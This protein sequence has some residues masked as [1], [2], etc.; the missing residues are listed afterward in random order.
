MPDNK[1]EII[2]E[3]QGQQAV[4]TIN[5]VG[6]A[7]KGLDK[8][9]VNA[10]PA[11]I[12]FGR[13]I[14]D[15]P[16]GLIGIANNID[17]LISS[18]QALKTQSGS[19][20]AAFKALAGSLI[21][22]AGIGIAISAVTSAL[23]AFGPKLFGASKEAKE[24]DKALSGVAKS[25][26]DDLVKLQTYASFATD[27]TKSYD[28]RKKAV[29]A[30]KHEYP[31]YLKNIDD[32]AILM[33]KA[34]EAINKSIDAILKR[35][36][37]KL[38]QDDIAK[39]VEESAKKIIE[40]QKNVFDAQQKYIN[41]QKHDTKVIGDV[42]NQ[43]AEALLKTGRAATDAGLGFSKLAQ[44]ANRSF[45]NRPEEQIKRIK[46]Q[47]QALVAPLLTISDEFADFGKVFDGKA[48][49][50]K[51]IREE[52]EKLAKLPQVGNALNQISGVFENIGTAIEKVDQEELKKKTK[53]IEDFVRQVRAMNDI[54]KVPAGPVKLP[55]IDTSSFDAAKVELEKKIA[56]INAIISQ[57]AVDLVV[58]ISE[59]IGNALSGAKNPF[60]AIFEI[61]GNGL[62][63]LG[64]YIIT[65]STLMKALQKAL[66][67]IGTLGITG[68]AI[69]AAMVALGTILKNKVNSTKF[70]EGG[71]VSGPLNA[72]I[73]EAGQSEVILPLS[74][75]SGL[76]NNSGAMILETRISGQDLLLVQ[77]R[78]QA[79]RGRTFG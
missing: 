66:E 38:L 76:L 23:I 30:L 24:L 37:I 74:R 11:L 2:I 21:G 60:A 29:Q 33:G 9:V 10:T 25:A 40:I 58:G 42:Y 7:M 70:A 50:V 41:E 3:A 4:K 46:E 15:A 35:S 61:L 27:V 52:F 6:K 68:I 5:D 44:A 31:E 55:P 8:S 63:S 65:T 39:A 19:A 59:G 78:A 20:G 13:V 54:A 43:Q 16:F 56:D 14:Q 72:Q 75:L 57:T 18:F 1:L 12:N 32:E 62:I 69:G 22:P 34:T 79:S 73:G 53:S 77:A 17:P 48:D 45:E 51:P 47:L 49:K 28:E 71:I 64:K 67:S 36:V 26:A